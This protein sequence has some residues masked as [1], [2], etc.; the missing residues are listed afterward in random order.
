[1]TKRFRQ[2]KSEIWDA[3][4]VKD[5][6]G[7]KEKPNPFRFLA[8]SGLPQGAFEFRRDPGKARG[9]MEWLESRV[10]DIIFEG[11]P[12]RAVG[13]VEWANTYI[14]S[15]YKR[16]LK[17]GS[18]E[19]RKA[20]ITPSRFPAEESQFAIDIRF[21]QPIHADRVGLIYTRVFSDLRGIT[22]T[23]ESEI[24]QSLAAGLAEG[25]GPRAIARDLINRIEKG[26]GTMAIVDEAG[27]VR[28]R[29][30]QRA[31]ILARTEVIRAH[32]VATINSYREAGIEG[33]RVLAEWATAGDDR[34]CDAC[35]DMEGKIFPLD[36]IENLIPLHPQCRCVAL[37]YT[38]KL[39]GQGWKRT[40]DGAWIS[41][42]GAE[43]RAEV[44]RTLREA[45]GAARTPSARR[46]VAQ[47]RRTARRA[48]RARRRPRTVAR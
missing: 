15:A 23:M 36:V 39:G 25:K 19:L 46:R 43:R 28:M 22:N 26:K 34:V 11:A 31:R 24:S 32:H 40:N 6:F 44:S 1:M 37:P 7:L 38:G 45:R 20:G 47:G 42:E 13:E 17:R 12:R 8:D 2:I 18:D 5:V 29:A 16:G 27:T 41:P 14:D 30:L 3:V 21:N 4:V 48:A 35:A 9:F 10:D 33:V